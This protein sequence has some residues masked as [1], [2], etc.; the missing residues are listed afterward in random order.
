MT[1]IG[2]PP[3]KK[4][5]KLE[6]YQSFQALLNSQNSVKLQ[7]GKANYLFFARASESWQN[8]KRKRDLIFKMKRELLD[9][10]SD[11]FVESTA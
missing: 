1:L 9:F 3:Q 4:K 11:H 2:P 10:Q 7:A 8:H 5:T 6:R